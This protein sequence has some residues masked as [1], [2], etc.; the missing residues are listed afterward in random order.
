M[1]KQKRKTKTTP[2][3]LLGLISALWTTR[4]SVTYYL[5]FGFIVALVFS[6]KTVQNGPFGRPLLLTA[7][8]SKNQNRKEGQDNQRTM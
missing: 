6:S 4:W 1:I 7:K 8:W 3:G 2:A 5:I